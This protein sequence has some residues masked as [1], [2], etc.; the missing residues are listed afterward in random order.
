MMEEG[1][2]GRSRA[3]NNIAAMFVLHAS[4]CSPCVWPTEQRD[5]ADLIKKGFGIIC[6]ALFSYASVSVCLEVC[7]RQGGEVK[8]EMWAKQS[9]YLYYNI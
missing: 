7:W 5:Y 1:M 2:E 3:V 6:L 4:L 8:A 9:H